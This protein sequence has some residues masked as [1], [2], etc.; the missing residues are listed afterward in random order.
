[1]DSRVTSIVYGVQ[2]PDPI[3]FKIHI[4]DFQS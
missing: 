3:T 1:M 2:S 4:S